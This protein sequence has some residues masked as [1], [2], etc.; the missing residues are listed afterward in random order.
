MK[1]GIR[2]GLAV[3]VIAAVGGVGY[4]LW[5]RYQ[6]E[7]EEKNVLT[8]FGNI[9]IR[10]V[11]LAFEASGRIEKM[12][13][14][15]GDGIE[16]GALTAELD[17]KRLRDRVAQAEAQVAQQEQVVARLLAGSREE[18]IQKAA[19][20]VEAARAE[21]A[22]AQRN[23]ERLRN[24]LLG[25]AVSEKQVDDALAASDAAAARVA[26]ARELLVL[27]QKGPREEDIAA[28]KALLRLYEAELALRNTE[29]EDAR[30]YAPESGIIEKRILE[31]GDLASPQKPAFT[32]ALTDPVWVRAYIDEPDLGKIHAGM[33][34]EVVTDSYPEKAYSAW[35]GYISPT[36]EFTPKTVQTTEVRTSLVYQVRVYVDNPQNE[37]RLGMPVTVHIP[38]DQDTPTSGSVSLRSEGPQ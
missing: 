30:L 28:A 5:T 13:V 35:I 10:Q 9:D 32:L 37:L 23:Y 1:K 20:E 11:E 14:Q 6:R 36:A 26:A 34:A 21:A 31:P 16:S 19:A 4:S 27:A 12:Y 29:L 15:E 18:E 38:L 17:T 33:K 7:E 2:F 3:L 24:L 25:N 8:L 22:N